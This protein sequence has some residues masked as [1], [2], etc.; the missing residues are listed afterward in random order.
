MG[1]FSFI[2]VGFSRWLDI[3]SQGS[4]STSCRVGNR[5]SGVCSISAVKLAFVISKLCPPYNALVVRSGGVGCYFTF[6]FLWLR[7]AHCYASDHVLA[8][9]ALRFKRASGF[10][11]CPVATTLS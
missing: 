3:V 8:E 6:R 10:G 7:S 9:L 2:P 4:G 1:V 11:E 5:A